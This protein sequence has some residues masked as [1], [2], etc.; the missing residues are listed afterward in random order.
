MGYFDGLADASFKQDSNGNSVFYPWGVL[1]KGRVLPDA[2]THATLRTFIKRYYM[3][4]LPVI[5]V[6][7][8]LRL[9]W[10]L[11]PAAIGLLAWFLLT[12]RSLLRNCPV[13]EEKLT[14][15][16]GYSNSAASHNKPTL[17]A[18][19]V[20]SLLMS[21]GGVL[22]LITGKALI[23]VAL[24]GLF[25]LCSGVFVYMLRVKYAKA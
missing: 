11:L 7:S 16:E 8:V 1:G 24:I 13:S 3:V 2:E 19:L 4:T 17:W 12:T 20:V 5:I 21:L 14:L 25:G 15:K 9:W 6:L 10:L 22:L 18:L 23:G